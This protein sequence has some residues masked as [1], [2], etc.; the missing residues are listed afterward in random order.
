VRPLF[1]GG[2]PRSGTTLLRCLLN[3]HPDL[4]MPAETDFVIPLWTFRARYGD[5]RRP[6][7]RR[8]LAE[9]IFN[10]DG[11]GGRRIRAGSF[12]RREAIERVV[13]SAP[14]LGSVFSTCFEMYAEA[15]GKSRWGDKRPGYAG[16]IGAIF[17]LFPDAQFINVVRD[18]RAAVSSI[19]RV[20]WDEQDVAVPSAAAMWLSSVRRV[21]AHVRR[22][23]PDQL[24]DV[25]YED[26]VR[27]PAATLARI[28]EFAGLRGGSAIDEMLTR[29]RRGKF[30]EGWHTLISEPI[31]TATIES[32]RERL[33]PSE[34]ALV[35]RA[36]APYL[37]RFG[38]VADL[39]A[40]PRRTELRELRRQRRRRARKWRRRATEELKRRA[41]VYRYPVA[42]P[43]AF[44]AE[45]QP[46]FGSGGLAPAGA[47]RVRAA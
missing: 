10:T 20:G 35:E 40:A 4:A 18:P 44:A 23:R 6:E 26:M 14:T 7:N 22:L 41:L 8:A 37:E 36:A 1:V 19:V 5:L 42:A 15:H 3:N 2:C 45:P 47:A 17:G 21:D 12:G 13:A 32:W 30:R 33:E 9:W 31:T 39:G 28:C 11:T 34:A 25:R 16:F 29:E 38:Y 43:P 27:D 24:L 46:A